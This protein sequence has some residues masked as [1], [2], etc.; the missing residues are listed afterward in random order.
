MD[1]EQSLTRLRVADA[2]AVAAPILPA[3]AIVSM[4]MTIT[5]ERHRQL[6]CGSL[7]AQVFGAIPTALMALPT[8][9]LVA[10]VVA[11]AL[12]TRLQW[13]AAFGLLLSLVTLPAT[14]LSLFSSCSP[15]IPTYH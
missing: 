3:I 6:V 11:I 14:A 1:A 12:K 15:G 2:L 10:A 7:L 13:I 4:F 8:L 9:G 5:A